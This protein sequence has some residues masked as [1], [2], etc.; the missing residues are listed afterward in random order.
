[1][2][3]DKPWTPGPWF[4]TGSGDSVYALNEQGHNRMYIAANGGWQRE[5]PDCVRTSFE[6]I[7]ANAHLIAAVPEQ[8]TRLSETNNLLQ[9]LLD[10]ERVHESYR[11]EIAVQIA[12][13]AEALAKARGEQS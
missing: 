5:Y 1:M 11:S 12:Y 9:R 6:E 13:N 8:H 10:D 7:K 4:V 3:S 2:L